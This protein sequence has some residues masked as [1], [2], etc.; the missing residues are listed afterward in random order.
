MKNY[1][2]LMNSLNNDKNLRVMTDWEVKL[3]RELFLEAF[4]DLNECCEKYGLTVMLI[5][6]SVLGAIRHEGFI[7]WDD[8]L[9]LAMSRHDYE[10]LKDIFDKELGDKYILSSPNYKNN[11]NDRYPMML[12]K[13]TLCVEAGMRKDD[14]NAKIKVDI[15]II[16]N[17]P[18]NSITRIIKGCIC[19]FLMF[20]SSN[21][22]SY[23]NDNEE[24]KRYMSKTKEGEKIYKRRKNIGRL[25]SFFS[26]QKWV[27]LTDSAFQYNKESCLMGIPSGRGHYFGEIRPKET[28]FPV[29]KGV[30]ENVEVNLPCNSD[31]YLSNLYGKDYMIIPPVEKREKHFIFDIKFSKR[32]NNEK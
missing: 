8:D 13:D 14:D 30:F 21:V 7:P 15:F 28:F 19:S 6:G 29:A 25:F 18:E 9:D 24:L 27:N 16:D 26:F 3:L 31:D 2:K 32:G 10:I 23:E 22:Y 4:F 17:I 20:V 11:A 12:I 5:G 1:K